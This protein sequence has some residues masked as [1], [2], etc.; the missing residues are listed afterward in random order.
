MFYICI[1]YICITFSMKPKL[2][3]YLILK[4]YNLN[5]FFCSLLPDFQIL[6]IVSIFPSHL[7]LSTYYYQPSSGPIHQ[8]DYNVLSNGLFLYLIWPPPN[9]NSHKSNHFSIRFEILGKWLNLPYALI[10]LSDK[11]IIDRHFSVIPAY[12]ILSTS[13]VQRRE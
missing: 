1:I 5:P 6:F 7:F 10:S 12:H 9:P 4:N 3:T 8:D 11:W 2:V 13:K